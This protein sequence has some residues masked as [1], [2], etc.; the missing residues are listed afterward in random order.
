MYTFEAAILQQQQKANKKE[1]ELVGLKNK[2]R[3][4]GFT[5]SDT[6]DFWASF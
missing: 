1:T 3:M 4:R 5:V 2:F 6:I